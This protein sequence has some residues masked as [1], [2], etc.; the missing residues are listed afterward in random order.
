MDQCM[1]SLD[2]IEAKEGETVTLFGQD[3]EDMISI[4]E[5]AGILGTINYEIVCMISRRV[6]RVYTRGGK[7]VGIT[8]YLK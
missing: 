4:D 8:D 3:G 6:P 7:T 1:I 5:I 2:G